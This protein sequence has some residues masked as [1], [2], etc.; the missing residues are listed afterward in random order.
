VGKKWKIAALVVVIIISGVYLSLRSG[1]LTEPFRRIVLHPLTR[2]IP[3]PVTVGRISLSL[4]P[5]SLV[6]SDVSI[7]ESKEPPRPLVEV[8]EIRINFSLWSLLTEVTIINK[9][10]LTEPRFHLDRLS[11]GATATKWPPEWLQGGREGPLRKPSLVVVRKFQV[12]DGSLKLGDASGN[13]AAGM[14]RFDAEINPSLDMKTYEV[15]LKGEGAHFRAGDYKKSLERA[16]LVFSATGDGILIRNADLL[17]GDSR[18]SGSGMIKN[19]SAPEYSA[20]IDASFPLSELHPFFQAAKNLSG[21][22]HINGRLTGRERTF[23]ISGE[24][25]LKDLNWKDAPVGGIHAGFEYKDRTLSMSRLSAAVFNGTARGAGEIRLADMPPDYRFSLDVDGISVGDLTRLAGRGDILPDHRMKGHLEMAGK[26]TTRES[27]TGSGTLQL[28]LPSGKRGSGSP[29]ADWIA[30]VNRIGK[31]QGSVKIDKGRLQLDSVTAETGDTNAEV[32]GVLRTDGTVEG[33]FHLASREVHEFTPLMKLDYVSGTGELTGKVSGP[34]RRPTVVGEGTLKDAEIRGR[35]FDSVSGRIEY[36]HPRLDFHS[37]RFVARASQYE[38][39]GYLSFD[40]AYPARPYFNLVANIR[41]GNPGEVV[42]L[43]YRELPITVPVDGE[44]RAEGQ[45]KDFSVTGRLTTGPGTVYGQEIDVGEA[46][47]TVTRHAVSLKQVR[48]TLGSTTVTGEGR[49]EYHGRFEFE[50][51]S[52]GGRLEDV[53]WIRDHW[54][55]LSAMVSGH[56]RGGGPLKQPEFKGGF[57][58]NG[59]RYRNQPFGNGSF[60]GTVADQRLSFMVVLDNGLSSKGS[61]TFAGELPF[62]MEVALDRFQALPVLGLLNVHPPEGIGKLSA[63]GSGILG[64]RGTLKNL[65]NTAMSLRLNPFT[66]SVGPVT[67]TN[68]KAIQVEMSGGAVVIQSLQLAGDQTQLDVTGGFEIRKDYHVSIN[69][70]A[71]LGL[72]STLTQDITLAHGKALVGVQIEEAWDDPS[73]RGNL[74]VQNGRL[75]SQTLGQLLVVDTLEMNF[76]KKQAVLDTFDGKLGGGKVSATGKW[77]L[78]GFKV[79]N[80]AVNLDI[81]SVRFVPA[82]GLSTTVDASLAYTGKD[83]TRSINGEVF[84]QRASYDRRLDWKT[85]GVE[86]I[87]RNKA[88]A[89]E[90]SELADTRLKIQVTGKRNIQVNNNMAKVPFEIDLLLKGTVGQPVLLGRLEAT[91]GTIYFRNNE[92]KVTSA[93]VDFIDPDRIRPIFDI[94]ATSRIRSYLVNLSLVGPPDRFDL[95]L[96]SDP[97]LGDHEILALLTFGLEPEE[98]D[99]PTME[100]LGAS[101][102]ADILFGGMIEEKVKTLTGIDRFQVDPYYSSNKSASTARVTVSKRLWEDSLYVTYATTLDASGEDIIQMEYIINDNISLVG[103]R[104]ELGYVGADLKFRFEFR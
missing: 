51:E 99:E 22:A 56:L 11:P 65:K 72:L 101:E 3:W 77:E 27:L 104:E 31:I 38:L 21:G 103:I 18:A 47:L 49:I 81:R 79:G 93:S 20:T 58:L 1:L 94:H 8:K 62:E 87:K 25:D 64:A 100:L 9:I 35:R 92:F 57:D 5:S 46:D 40:H 59:I 66:L 61:V 67:L 69:G 82:P 63:E 44:I 52:N 73:F 29:P 7:L 32:T 36:R 96:S 88:K 83:D 60:K 34:L 76:N 16:E 53:T 10:R 45:P 74:S 4:F 43:F 23:S 97:P 2:Q 78:D 24:T 19:L 17:S 85:L 70:E 28:R 6:I 98:I 55:G 41:S 71:D 14:N 13:W 75:I 37:A 42:A 84:V 12:K 95:T 80:F 33:D 54:E 68:T 89:K 90:E 15:R 30:W 48:A 86:L 50:A 26:G 91:G 39:E 102:A